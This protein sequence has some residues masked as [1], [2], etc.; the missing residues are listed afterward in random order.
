MG[1]KAFGE[2][3]PHA[4]ESVYLTPERLLVSTSPDSRKTALRSC[5]R[6]TAGAGCTVCDL[7]HNIKTLLR[8]RAWAAAF[9]RGRRDAWTSESGGVTTT[10][11]RR[12][13]LSRVKT[14]DT[15]AQNE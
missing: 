10:N 3:N 11:A 13:D 6:G 5:V 7:R 2:T 14:A 9:P 8:R 15:V 1:A 12:V 4:C